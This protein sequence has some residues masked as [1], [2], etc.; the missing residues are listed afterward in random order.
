[1]KKTK[2]LLLYTL[3]TSFLLSTALTTYAGTWTQ[4]QKGWKYKN[5]N[6]QDMTGWILDNGKYYYIGNDGY[7]LSNCKTPDGYTVNY[8][9]EWIEGVNDSIKRTAKSGEWNVSSETVSDIIL[10]GNG[11]IGVFES[12]A[13]YNYGDIT[14]N[15]SGSEYSLMIGVRLTTSRN[16]NGL[17]QMLRL[18]GY[19]NVDEIY[20]TLYQSFEGTESPI[21]LKSF[22]DIA[23]HQ[24]KAVNNGN[25]ITYI[26][27]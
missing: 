27:K 26:I 22:V 20:N 9:G 21:N 18:T 5:E 3:T 14:F 25:S 19:T 11:L 16:Q 8:N 1:M 6:N 15:K 7:M 10:Q 13:E 4:D 24:I 12:R 17:K 2:Q 23:G